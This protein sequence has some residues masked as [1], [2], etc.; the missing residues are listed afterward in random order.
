MRFMRFRIFRLGIVI[1][2]MRTR[3]SRKTTSAFPHNK[4]I[5]SY[6]ISLKASKTPTL[7]TLLPTLT[8]R[9]QAKQKGMQRKNCI[10]YRILISDGFQ[11]V[12]DQNILIARQHDLQK[13]IRL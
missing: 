9:K 5:H 12:H 4:A 13:I 8:L 6:Y 2:Q 3:L 7:P 10:P 11:E 1:V